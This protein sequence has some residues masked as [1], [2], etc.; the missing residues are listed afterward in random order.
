[1][2]CETSVKSMSELIIPYFYH[3]P[4]QNTILNKK[5]QV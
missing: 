3:S 1:L 2:A 5:F 4:D